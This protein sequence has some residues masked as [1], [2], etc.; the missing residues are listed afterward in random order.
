MHDRHDCDRDRS[1][2]PLTDADDHDRLRKI[3][4]L[5]ASAYFVLAGLFVWN[6]VRDQKLSKT[7]RQE[8][9]VQQQEAAHNAQIAAVKQTVY[10]ACLASGP[11]LIAVNRF[12]DGERELARVTLA[13]ARGIRDATP[14]SDPSYLARKVAVERLERVR[15]EVTQVPPFHV[16]TKAECVKQAAATVGR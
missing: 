4:V 13:N 7:Q 12:L 6:L 9:S 8:V 15:S 3:L 1:S 5:V 14:T 16:P 11:T 2:V 10:R